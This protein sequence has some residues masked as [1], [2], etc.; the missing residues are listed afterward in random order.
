MF[1][2]GKLV[3][4]G[5]S[6]SWPILGHSSGLPETLLVNRAAKAAP[7]RS[8]RSGPCVRNSKGR[9]VTCGGRQDSAESWGQKQQHEEMVPSFRLD[10]ICSDV[11][12]RFWE[13][14]VRL[15]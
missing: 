2:P 14:R 7:G 4:V 11:K 5:N 13:T 12:L 9:A 3:H 8:T 10:F 6:S 1:Q 15:Q